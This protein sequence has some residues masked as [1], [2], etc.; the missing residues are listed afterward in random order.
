MRKTILLFPIVPLLII[1][2]L[3]AGHPAQQG[4]PSL[5][6]VLREIDALE[7]CGEPVPLENRDVRERLEKE[8]LLS[9]WDRPQVILWL[10]RSTRYL[11]IIESMLRE[12][13]MPE[14]LKFLSIAES[15]LRP[16]AGSPDGAIGFWQFMRETGLKYGLEI[17]GRVDERRNI[18]AS[19]K[20]AIQYLTALKEDFG[21]WSLAVAAFNMGEDGLMAEILEQN[22]RDYYLLY[23]P[24]ETQRYIFRVLS[25]KLIL[26]DPD[27]YGFK[28]E[29]SDYYAPLDYDEVSVRCEQ[30]IP[31][32][33]I[34]QA[35][36]THFKAIKDLNPEIRGHYLPKGDH[37]ILIPRG[38]AFGFGERYEQLAKRLEQDGRQRIYIVESGD[39]LSLIAEKFGVPLS[40]LIIW[41]RLS[42]GRPI[43]PG[44]RLIIYPQDLAE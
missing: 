19:T 22:T 10:K 3:E 20:A 11:P 16:H 42:L 40:A 43:H 25:V 24:L 7:F 28:L 38:A 37:R 30:E 8:V 21:S 31:I 18:F 23:L 32:R 15:A 6:S 17:S 26:N 44:D 35:A 33:M 13:G 2:A 36:G 14:D 29:K 27:R 41:N 39:N 1:G 12:K 4:S 9:V 34:A 5:I